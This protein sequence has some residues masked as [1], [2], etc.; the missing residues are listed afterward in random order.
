MKKGFRF[1]IPAAFM[2]LNILPLFSADSINGYMI[3]EYYVI[4]SGDEGIDGQHGFW[5][6]RIY[7]GYD[8]DLGDGWSARI[9]LEM[10][11]KAFSSDK[12]I[13]FVKNAHIKKKL[14]ANLSLIGG[15]IEPPSFSSV[16]GFWGLR[17]VEKTVA[18]F[19]KFASSRD[20]GLGLE[21][22]SKSGLSWTVMYGNY[23]G[24][25][26]E[27]NKG[28]AIYGR[29]GYE[30]KSLFLEANGHIASSGSKQITFLSFFAG[31]K[32][33]WGRAG[34]GYVHR[35]DSPEE[36]EDVSNG[37]ISAMA[38][39]KLG[40]KSEVYARYDHLT[41]YNFK[42]IGDYLPVLASEYKARLLMAGL[43]IKVNKMVELIPNVKYVFYGEGMDNTKPDGDIHILLTGKISFKSEI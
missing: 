20:F 39:F 27:S 38:A 4:S 12:I 8:T 33:N 5:L 30:T 11:G 2:L 32:G 34:A 13:P 18:D 25:A 26:D 24:E 23:S 1:L 40:K 7:F 3:P 19:F 15:I 17:Q 22:K 42:D 14:S 43:R 16:E 10:N 29:I 41:D 35:N 6:R 37:A 31:L 21:G 9:R 36:G 28:K